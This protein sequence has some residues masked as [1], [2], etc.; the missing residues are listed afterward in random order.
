MQKQPDDRPNNTHE[1]RDRLRAISRQIPLSVGNTLLS[2]A[3][4][5]FREESSEDVPPI[6]PTD[7][8]HNVH[9]VL[10]RSRFMPE[11]MGRKYAFGGLFAVLILCAFFGSVVVQTFFSEPL[12]LLIQQPI[13]TISADAQLPSKLSPQWLMEILEQGVRDRLCCAEVLIDSNLTRQ[14]TYFSNAVEDSSKA[15]VYVSPTLRCAD[16]FCLLE[17]ELSQNGIRY[18]QQKLIFSNT[19]LSSW[20]EHARSATFDLLEQSALH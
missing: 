2:E 15:Q 14:K 17:L 12:R 8:T 6:V 10:R 4:P 11:F 18:S 19:P 1:L 3:E 13:F 5:C 9:S 20:V 16:S 7:L